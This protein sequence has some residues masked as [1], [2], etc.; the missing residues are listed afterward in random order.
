MQNIVVDGVEYRVRVVYESLSRSFSIVEGPNGG[1]AI[2]ARTIRD[3]IGTKYDYEMRVEP[4]LRYPED[5]DAFYEVISAPVESHMVEMPYGSGVM[6]FE[7]MIVSGEDTYRGILVNRN[8]WQG[9]RVQFKP[10]LP[11]RTR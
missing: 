10:I 1:T 2:T 7:A 5:Y 4:D 3:I 9:L 11:Q 8:A 6:K